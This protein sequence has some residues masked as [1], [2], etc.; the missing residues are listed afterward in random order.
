MCMQQVRRKVMIQDS[1]C[2]ELEQVFD[3]FPRYLIKI[4]LGDFNA[5]EGR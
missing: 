1:F 5:K 2:D 4:L 3:D